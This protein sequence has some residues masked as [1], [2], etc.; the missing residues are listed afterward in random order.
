MGGWGGI[1]WLVFRYA[2]GAEDISSLGGGLS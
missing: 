1:P 2:K